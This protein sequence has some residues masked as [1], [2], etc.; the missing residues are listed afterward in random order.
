MSD[1]EVQY[2]ITTRTSIAGG[3][4]YTLKLESF[5]HLE[6]LFYMSNQGFY[7]DS[8]QDVINQAQ[9][10]AQQRV[11]EHEWVTSENGTFSVD[12]PD[13][14]PTPDQDPVIGAEQPLGPPT[15][16]LD[17]VEGVN[18]RYYSPDF[19]PV[20]N[21]MEDE[22]EPDWE[23]HWDETPPVKPILERNFE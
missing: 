13:A 21:E 23:P 4:N 1:I 3:T 8:K 6:Q 2:E 16:V 9:E 11:N 15:P 5:Y 19:P 18:R 17:I 10:F 7:G 14:P 12:G 20:I 22:A